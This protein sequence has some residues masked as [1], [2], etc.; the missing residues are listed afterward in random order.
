MESFFGNA[1]GIVHTIFA[2]IAMLSGAWVLLQPKGGT[3][4]RQMGYVYVGAMLLMLL[5]AFGIYRLFGGFGIF[6][7]F[8]LISF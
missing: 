3:R 1:I 7:F 2:V 5:T 8:A 4:H 6:H